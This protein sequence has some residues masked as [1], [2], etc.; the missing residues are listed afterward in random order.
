MKLIIKL[1]SVDETLLSEAI[2]ST[3]L[4]IV[5]IDV[6]QESNKWNKY[7]LF[8]RDIYFSLKLK[9]LK[10]KGFP[11]IKLVLNFVKKIKEDYL[12]IIDIQKQVFYGI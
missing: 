2:N 3:D 12:I 4:L 11:R 1:Y 7:N 9:I 8:N 5:E 6:S 10:Y